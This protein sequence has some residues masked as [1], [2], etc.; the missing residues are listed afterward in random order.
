MKM[1]KVT[2]DALNYYRKSVKGNKNITEEQARAKLT[3]NVKLVQAETPERVLRIG[4]FSKVY[5]YH[6]L[7]ITVRNGKVIKIV[8]HKRPRFSK[9]RY[10]ELSKALGIKDIKYYRK[11]CI[12]R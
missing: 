5:M 6:D 11:H 9:K 8:N 3:R 4:L 12:A 1:L 2:N 7:H 10:I